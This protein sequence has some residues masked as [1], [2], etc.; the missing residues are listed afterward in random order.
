MKINYENSTIEM[1]KTE[2]KEAGEYGSAKYQELIN[3]RTAF[4]NFNI[5]IIKTPSPKKD[6]YRK[7]TYDYME[8]FIEIYHNDL[9]NEFNQR[10]GIYNGQKQNLTE[11]DTYIDVRNWFL[12]KCPEVKIFIESVIK[13]REEERE[14][15]RKAKI[16]VFKIPET[17]NAE[18][19]E[20]ENAE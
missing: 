12:V 17:K 2:S 14:K 6:I 5:V 15:R 3:I 16:E 7:L 4:P 8:K 1:T 18:I 10:R 13:R 9:L 11:K 19:P 20:T